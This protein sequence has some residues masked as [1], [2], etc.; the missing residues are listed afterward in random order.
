VLEQRDQDRLQAPRA[1]VLEALVDLRGNASDLLDRRIRELQ[2][3][4][5]G[6]DQGLVLPQQ[7]VLRLPEYTGEILLA[8]GIQVDADAETPLQLGD[9]VARLR[10]VERPGRNEEE[11]VRADDAVL[12]GDGA[13]LDDGQEVPLHALPAHIGADAAALTRDLVD[14]VQE[15][16]AHLLGALER[17]VD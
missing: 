15:D 12:R 2:A 1:D 7:R 17:L 13:A 11:V 5:L 8:Q 6:G 9:E 10:D 3:D 14:L 16:D 4:A